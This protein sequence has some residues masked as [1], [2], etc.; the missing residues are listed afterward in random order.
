MSRVRKQLLV[1]FVLVAAIVATLIL[2]GPSIQRSILY[3]K[4][5]GL[6]PVV[7]QTAEQLLAR[8]QSVLET[9]A[10]LV[11]R[12][13]QPGLS[14]TQ[15]VALE[16]Q[17]G[18]R[19][20]D[21]LRALYRWRNGFAPNSTVGLLMG[22]RFVPLD[23][24]VRE[25][26]L[27]GQQVASAPMQQRTAFSVFAGYR[28]GWVQIL[29]DGAGDGYFYDPKRSDAEGAFFHHFAEMGYYVW[30]PSL[31]NFLAGV[32]ECYESQAVKVAAD[33]KSLDEDFD[34]TE[35]IWARFAKSSENGG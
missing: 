11:A 34:R 10:P 26:A 33:G 7:S 9:N 4:P 22:Q 24:V 27:I 21:D 5:R 6:P 29:D 28:T 2:A 12:S 3:P 30:F 19:L 32:I 17:G 8:L 18:F 25:R 14:D 35:K 13:L 15:I 31:R 1:A 20:S 16:G 23:E